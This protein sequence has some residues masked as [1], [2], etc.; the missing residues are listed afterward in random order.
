MSTVLSRDNKPLVCV[1]WDD[2]HAMLAGDY[3]Q[4]EVDMQFHKASRYYAFGLLL[5][6]NEKGVTIA[7]EWCEEGWRGLNFIPAGM[8]VEVI[9][10]GVPKRKKPKKI[11]VVETKIGQPLN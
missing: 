8:V 5:L 6:N 9:D 1:V 4:Q 10:L 7:T 11:K 2:A 3:T